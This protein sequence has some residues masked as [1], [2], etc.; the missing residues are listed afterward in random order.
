MRG[1]VFCFLVGL[2]GLLSS[3]QARTWTSLK[4][5]FKLEGD[6]IASNETTAILKRSG[7]GRLAAVELNELSVSDRQYVRAQASDLKT[8]QSDQDMQ[9][10]TSKSGLKIRGKVL[11]FGKQDFTLEKLRGVATLNGK[12][13][14]TLDPLHQSIA[15]RVLSVLEH[16]KIDSE[17]DL[18]QFTKQLGGKPKTYPLEG[19]LM[20]LQSGDEI[21]VPFFLFSERDLNVL[22]P[23][24]EEWLQ[25]QES[26]AERE[27]QNLM[28]RTEAMHH[29]QAMAN[30]MQRQQME[31]LK[32]N[33]LAAQ[34][35]LTSIWEVGLKPAPGVYGRPI[36][37]MVTA[38]NS[39]IA[40][41]MVLPN[42]PGYQL[43]GVR[44]A[45]W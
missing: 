16:V 24:W 2:S 40:T 34:T 1:I 28:M 29:Q 39:Q 20:K 37:V 15:L 41:Q 45:S 36:S 10:W 8:S 11:A 22:K 33:M 19:V 13:F 44:K 26:D 32:F 7:S 14:S 30:E 17:A 43:I 38:R 12:A 4:G 9:V 23:G 18:N 42:Y 6:L 35:G 27:R 5:D 3:A 25:S 31:I 21:A